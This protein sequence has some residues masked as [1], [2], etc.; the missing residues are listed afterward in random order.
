MFFNLCVKTLNITYI[1]TDGIYE[2]NSINRYSKTFTIVIDIDIM[3]NI[4][5]LVIS[6]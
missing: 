4:F 5:I 6:I 1:K 2:I 3:C